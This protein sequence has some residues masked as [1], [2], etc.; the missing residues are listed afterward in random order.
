MNNFN[1]EV[2]YARFKI[3]YPKTILP[4]INFL[5]WFIGFVEGSG[6]FIVAKR[7]DLSFAITQ[8]TVDVQI[9]Y[10]IKNTL[11]F[12]SVIQQSKKQ[13]THRFVVQDVENVSILCLLFNGNIVL[14]TRNLRFISFLSN[15]NERLA[16][17]N[18]IIVQPVFTTVLP[19]VI[20]DSWFCGFSDSKG[21]FSCSLLSNSLHFRFRFILTQKWD[22][23]KT[24][25]L[26]LMNDLKLYYNVESAVCPHS[27]PL[28]WELRIN[29]LSNCCKLFPYF[30]RHKLL[31]KKNKSYI[32][33]KDLHSK[34]L[35]KQH[36]IESKRSNLI[37]LA[38]QVN[39]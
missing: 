18:L 1:F 4:S 31:T 21:C 2:F 32:I 22:A 8:S 17:K 19:F 33:W 25:L 14:P 3:K 10:L 29:G 12:G 23:N 26:H 15:L 13:S 34:L 6:T 28:V 16:K 35:E 27:A 24:V 20:N 30:D 9:L 38:S 36:L 5:E 37:K 39:Q 11:N 7:G